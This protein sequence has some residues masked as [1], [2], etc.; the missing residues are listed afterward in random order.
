MHSKQAKEEV[1]EEDE[2]EEVDCKSANSNASRVNSRAVIPGDN[3]TY[4]RKMMIKIVW[5]VKIFLL[6]KLRNQVAEDNECTHLPFI[7]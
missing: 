3:V 6:N 1:D 2:E 5:T 7:T 4:D